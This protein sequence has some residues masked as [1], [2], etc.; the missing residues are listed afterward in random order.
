MPAKKSTSA[1]FNKKLEEDIKK[2]DIKLAKLRLE[3][4]RRMGLS[5][6]GK[7]MKYKV[8]GLSTKKKK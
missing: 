5:D 3:Q 1:K 4:N 8:G 2:L 7:S 6:D